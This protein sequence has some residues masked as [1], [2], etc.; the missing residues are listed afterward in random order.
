YTTVLLSCLSLFPYATLFR[1]DLCLALFASSHGCGLLTGKI[2]DLAVQ[3]LEVLEQLVEKV[4]NDLL[5]P[6]LRNADGVEAVVPEQGG[7]ADR[8][9]TRLNSVTWPSRMPAS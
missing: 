5:S 6:R 1:S 4:P 9:S 8:K 7:E 3:L 2:V